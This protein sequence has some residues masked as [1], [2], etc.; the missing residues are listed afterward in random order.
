MAITDFLHS[1]SE[2]RM[3]GE[4]VVAQTLMQ[5]QVGGRLP[6][7]PSEMAG[8]WRTQCRVSCPSLMGQW[9]DRPLWHTNRHT[10]T[11]GRGLREARRNGQKQGPR[12]RQGERWWGRGLAEADGGRLRAGRMCRATG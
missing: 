3:A 12:D 8:P 9:P 7:L 10:Q 6:P 11:S 1:G 4:V 2:L 5:G